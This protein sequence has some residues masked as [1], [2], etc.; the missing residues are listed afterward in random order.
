MFC[1]ILNL[2]DLIWESGY[3]QLLNIQF[4]VYK[5]SFNLS[6]SCLTYYKLYIVGVID[7]YIYFF[8]KLFIYYIIDVENFTQ[9]AVVPTDSTV[10]IHI[11]S[12][13]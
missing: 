13:F 9:T 8:L 2:Y 5:T 10:T 1:G 12:P 6:E 3:T 11:Y 7:I 4:S